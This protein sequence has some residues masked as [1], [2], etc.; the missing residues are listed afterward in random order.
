MIS[1]RY[2][3]FF[4]VWIVI[5]HQDPWG[6]LH[7]PFGNQRWF[8]GKSTIELDDVGRF[9]HLETSIFRLLQISQ[10]AIFDGG[11]WMYWVFW[12]NQWGSHGNVMGLY[13]GNIT[14]SRDLIWF[15]QWT[16]V[17]DIFAQK[18]FVPL[19]TFWSLPG[20]RVWECPTIFHSCG[21]AQQKTAKRGCNDKKNKTWD[22]TWNFIFP[23]TNQDQATFTNKMWTSVQSWN[24]DVYPLVI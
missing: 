6:Y 18:V 21:A 8:A 15:N 4:L 1:S 17:Y 2:S 10:L 19:R 11:Q 24:V 16:K 3:L 7:E 9:S 5:I 23:N 12:I 14:N 22:M 20:S 13:N